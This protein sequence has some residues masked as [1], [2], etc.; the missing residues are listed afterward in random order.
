MTII[1]TMVCCLLCTAGLIINLVKPWQILFFFHLKVG[2]IDY[3]VHPLWET[4]VDLVHPYCQDI[5]DSL[6]DNREWYQNMIGASPPESEDC[7]NQT[8]PTSANSQIALFDSAQTN[9]NDCSETESFVEFSDTKNCMKPQPNPSLLRHPSMPYA[10]GLEP[11]IE[12]DCELQM[13][14]QAV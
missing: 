8:K 13:V 4:W 2:F 10:P 7:C 12:E 14:D 11:Q 6:E 1:S 9:D 3:I 5:L